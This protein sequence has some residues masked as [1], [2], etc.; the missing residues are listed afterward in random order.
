MSTCTVLLIP[1]KEL[2]VQLQNR[3]MYLSPKVCQISG[4]WDSAPLFREISSKVME[5][6]ISKVSL[7]LSLSQLRLTLLSL[8]CHGKEMQSFTN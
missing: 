6:F 2:I 4:L 7:I 5:K 3:L 1:E 8:F